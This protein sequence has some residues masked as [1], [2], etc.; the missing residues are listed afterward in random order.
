MT[1]KIANITLPVD[2]EKLSVEIEKDLKAAEVYFEPPWIFDYGSGVK[3]LSISGILGEE[4]KLL[5]QIETDYLI[6]LENLSKKTM[7]FAVLI[8][9]DDQVSFWTLKKVT[10]GQNLIDV[11]LSDSTDLVKK[12]S[13]S[14]RVNAV[15]S[16]VCAR[17]DIYHN[18]SPVK[19]FS[20]QDFVSWWW[21]GRST[22][23]SLRIRFGPSYGATF[24][25]YTWTDNFTSWQ[26][27][28]ARKD[29]F[30]KV[31]SPSWSNIGAVWIGIY[32]DNVVAD[33]RLDRTCVGVG[34]LIEADDT[35]Y[36][37]IY[38]IKNF[39]W[40]ELAGRIAHVMYKMDLYDV[41]DYY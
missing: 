27:L 10:A 38:N 36:D 25:S 23:T 32:T 14:L 15:S 7:A 24:F 22:N 21:Y 17:W 5:S 19:D 39:S 12:G 40:Q 16:T 26:R 4:G 30:T 29:E 37:G 34:V 33:W 28:F 1:F 11:S 8:V 20:K 3:V 31:G 41:D 13:N 9:D 35:R 2:P 6:P 18:Y